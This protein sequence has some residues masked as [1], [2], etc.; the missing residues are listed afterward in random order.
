MLLFHFCYETAIT[1]NGKCFF[2]HIYTKNGTTLLAG[3]TIGNPACLQVWPSLKLGAIAPQHVTGNT[4]PKIGT[5]PEIR[6]T[7]EEENS[8][9]L[10]LAQNNL[11]RPR[12]KKKKNCFW[13][14]KDLAGPKCT[15]KVTKLYFNL[16]FYRLIFRYG[17][18]FYPV[19]I[20][21]FEYNAILKQ[22]G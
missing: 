12:E 18:F 17:V 16:K 2:Q 7:S 4:S 15:L 14:S 8:F 19:S 10:P 11:L 20:S 21:N 9:P 13:Y 3:G 6:A 5:L 1:F 22:R